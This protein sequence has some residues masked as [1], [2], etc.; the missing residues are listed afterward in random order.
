[1]LINPTPY[2]TVAYLQC[3]KHLIALQI[4]TLPWIDIM[5][6]STFFKIPQN[7]RTDI[8]TLDSLSRNYTD[9]MNNGGNLKNAK[10]HNNVIGKR[11]FNISLT[12]VI[13]RIIT[14]NNALIGMPTWTTHY[15][16]YLPASI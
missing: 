2:E 8:R 6:R 13:L 10:F 1:M 3:L 16:W 11:F 7:L 12:Q 9:F 5:M 4:F 15:S 14:L